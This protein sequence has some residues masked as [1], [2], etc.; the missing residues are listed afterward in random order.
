[1]K[2]GLISLG[3]AVVLLMSGCSD[4]KN[5]ATSG[6]GTLEA[7]EVLLS[8]KTAGTVVSMQVREGDLVA[9]GQIVALIDSEKV[10]LQK[11]QLLAGMQELR[12]NMINAKR[13]VQLSQDHFDNVA[14]KFQ[15]IKILWQDSSATLQ[16]FEDIE[17]AYKAASTQFENSRTAYDALTARQSQLQAQL[18]LLSSQLA[19]CRVVAPIVAT[20]LET[21]IEKGEIARPA[22]PIV[23]LAD[24][25]RMW[26]KIYVTEAEL[27]RIK[28]GATAEVQIASQPEKRFPGQVSWI[29][30]RA[31]FTPKNVQT[32]EARADLVYAVKI[33]TANPDGVLKIGMPADVYLR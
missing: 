10:F 28:I 3:V 2:H 13:A 31:E 26:I 11:Q 19:D 25:T 9:S 27:G 30:P 8:S 23:K 18:A 15:R 4:K 20:V 22:G 32:K 29:S 6:S 16:Q 21:Y 17:T 5:D 14:K 7:T 33:T 1:M 24:L 12:F